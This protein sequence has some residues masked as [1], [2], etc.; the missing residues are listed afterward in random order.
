MPLPSGS[1]RLDRERSA[2]EHIISLVPG[3]PLPIDSFELTGRAG[4]ASAF[5]V[6]TVAV[7]SAAAS[8]LAA[9]V[10]SIDRAAVAANFTASVE[11][12]GTSLPKWADLSGYYRTSDS[13]AE[14]PRFIQFHCNFP[15]HAAGV[16][17]RLGCEATRDAVQ[18][19][20]M[21]WEPLALE[22]ALIN[23][24]MIA[25]RLRT[26]DEWSRHPHAIA[27]APLPLIS[28]EQIG[29]GAPRPGHRRLRVLDCSRVLA[30]PVAG[31]TLAAHGADVLRVGS[32]HL[33]HVEMC[34]LLTG[35]GKRNTFVDL[36]GGDGRATFGSLLA[37]SDVWI[38]AYRPDAFAERGFSPEQA[39]PGSV[40][41][42]LSAFD[43]TGPWAG[44]RGFDSIVQSTSGIVEAGR[45]GAAASEPTPLPVQALDFATGYLAAFAATQ[46]VRHQAEVGGT[47]LAR[48]S[49]LRTRNWLVSLGGPSPFTPAAPTPDKQALHSVD[50]PAGRVTAARP[51]GGSWQHGPQPL[52]SSP[53]IWLD[54]GQI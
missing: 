27:T 53:P 38:D 48:L 50:T 40:T 26:M 7:A 35:F 28:I 32:P 41:V 6:D 19:A 8:N 42:Q 10:G 5:D 36:D 34:V 3:P 45:E 12:D 30:G 20:V 17:A 18:D 22:E 49:L 23:D 16:V 39:S 54:V 13:T 24:G 25:A 11:V 46:L 21:G 51:V 15:H 47:W 29:E 37:G 43:W 31:Q 33:P 1:N 4:F 14:H 52:G 2:I 44:R 9:G